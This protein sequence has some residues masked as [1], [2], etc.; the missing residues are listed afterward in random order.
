MKIS[1]H[2]ECPVDI[3][4]HIVNA[5][6]DESRER[7]DNGRTDLETVNI[8]GILPI[9]RIRP[10][11]IAFMASGL[12]SIQKYGL[13]D[14]EIGQTIL[15]KLLDGGAR[16]LTLMLL[17]I[18][19]EARSIDREI[20]PIMNE[21]WLEAALKEHGQAIANLCGVEAAQIALTQIR[22]LATA[23]TFAFHFIALVDSDLSRLSRVD[24]AELVVSFTSS[25]FQSVEPGSI[26]ETVQSL[27]QERHVIIKRIALK[28]I[29]HHYSDLKHLFWE[30]EGNPLDEIGLEPEVSQLIQA[31]SHTFNEDEMEQILQW[32]ES[33]QY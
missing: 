23:D 28:A 17:V 19:F 6:T 31:N 4:V 22:T 9:D 14:Q 3:L 21:Y 16:E 27:L 33:T 1:T 2:P 10:Q 15:P 11:H 29:T 5:I 30:W 18:I 13:M 7:I 12:K 8:I 20:L 26:E 32:I 24:Y 25:I